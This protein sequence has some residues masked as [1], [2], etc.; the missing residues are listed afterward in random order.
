MEF[1]SGWEG[2]LPTSLSAGTFTPF[3]GAGASSLRSREEISFDAHPWDKVGKT[4]VRI[5]I[6]VAGN[7]S[8]I[9]L[10]AFAQQRL[11]PSEDWL[12]EFMPI[13]SGR[14]DASASL[15][16]QLAGD[17]LIDLQVALVRAM[18]RLT[19]IFG[20]EFVKQVPS[21]RELPDC[22]VSFS[23][24]D[25]DEQDAWKKLCEAAAIA[26]KLSDR[27]KQD[28]SFR[29]AD[30]QWLPAKAR[31]AFNIARVY[32]RLAMLTCLLVGQEQEKDVKSLFRQQF[33]D[34]PDLLRVGAELNEANVPRGTLRLDMMQWLA[35]LL[36]Y[37][38]VYWI[39]RFPTTLEL[40]FELGLA[41]PA[42]PPRRP[43][44]AQAAQA[45]ASDAKEANA[46]DYIKE[47]ME[48][49]ESGMKPGNVVDPVYR[50]FY[51]A[52][53]AA[54][55]DQWERY[56]GLVLGRSAA[57]A[58]SGTEQVRRLTSGQVDLVEEA[59]IATNE[60][61]PRVGFMPI[62]ATTNYDSGLEL[63]F[64]EFEIPYHVLFPVQS[65]SADGLARLPWVFRTVLPGR[66]PNDTTMSSVDPA[67]PEKSPLKGP[68][69]VKLHGAPTLQEA[70]DGFGGYFKHKIVVS[71][72][73]Y[74]DALQEGSSTLHW[75]EHEMFKP[76]DDEEKHDPASRARSVWFLGYS[77]ADW[78]V[79]LRLYSHLRGTRRDE[80][81]LRA[82]NR[83]YDPFR[84][85]ILRPL[86]VLLC[87][88]DLNKVPNA[89]LEY[90]GDR[91]GKCGPAVQ[92]LLD[93]LRGRRW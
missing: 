8:R 77:I 13:P 46:A 19:A 42:G 69:I 28:A 9:F 54:L 68:V 75:F 85:A 33:K 79:R 50:R 35:D 74:L 1:L 78:N 25:E 2:E 81:P 12:N 5:Y 63:V 51:V 90:Y 89:I 37:S 29:G 17:D 72:K 34:N 92:R 48:Y 73:E 16:R 60:A 31:R 30:A 93:D 66:T 22:A 52:I 70:A 88:G 67:L 39:P 57:R 65:G 71:E 91:Y 87:R 59:A 56:E 43:E 47:L 3:L 45:F 40:A 18:R 86:K 21:L 24:Q 84:Q 76:L 49:C 44:L 83:D 62:A 26:K 80:R 53:A 15:P 11:Q 61:P 14:A 10:R 32:E 4:L 64:A 55:C 7:E 41:V 20:D 82:V 23:F 58:I 38:L 36:E 6:D 27:K